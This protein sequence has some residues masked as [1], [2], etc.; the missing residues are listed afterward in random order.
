[1][2]SDLPCFA[3]FTYMTFRMNGAPQFNLRDVERMRLSGLSFLF[4]ESGFSNFRAAFERESTVALSDDC[5]WG[6]PN[7]KRSDNIK[8]IDAETERLM[9]EIVGTEAFNEQVKDDRLPPWASA[10]A[11]IFIR[12]WLGP[13]SKYILDGVD[14]HSFDIHDP[15]IFEMAIADGRIKPF[16]RT[17]KPETDIK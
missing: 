5:P 7:D 4:N 10:A 6:T 13:T 16:E 17:P 14:N 8:K 2:I 11:S 12:P 9:K 1:M 15:S 3:E